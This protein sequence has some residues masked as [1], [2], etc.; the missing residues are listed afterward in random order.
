LNILASGGAPKPPYNFNKAYAIV[1]IPTFYTGRYTFLHEVGHLLSGLHSYDDPT[2]PLNDCG[3]GWNFGTPNNPLTSIMAEGSPRVL[4]FTNPNV[5]YN[6]L[7]TGLDFGNPLF[8]TYSMNNAKKLSNSM[9]TV[10]NN[11][12][13]WGISIDGGGDFCLDSPLTLDASVQT[14][15]NSQVP[16][17]PPYTYEWRWSAN[18]FFS[19]G[20]LI[21]S[22]SQ[23]VSVPP[24][25]SPS[26]WVQLKVTSNDGSVLITKR[27]ILNGLCQTAPPIDTKIDM[28]TTK[29][30]VEEFEVFPNPTSGT[31]QIELTSNTISDLY[32]TDTYGK[33]VK[34]IFEKGLNESYIHTINLTNM[35][36]GIYFCI[37]QS[38]E[39]KIIKKIII[40]H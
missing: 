6:G 31:I 1:E 22:N 24:Y 40:N 28:N 27:K 25:T 23:S 37:A 36:N 15:T 16:G 38:D 29:S 19:P 2:V 39:K 21:A 30:G 10:V 33:V 14:P 35:P 3:H 32:I 34:T 18:G 12:Q 11:Y 20:S 26:F 8:P 4:H 9:C 13:D 5:Y 17:Q 7:V